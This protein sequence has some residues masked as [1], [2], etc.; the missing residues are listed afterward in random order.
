MCLAEPYSPGLGAELSDQERAVRLGRSR[1]FAALSS[2]ARVVDLRDPAIQRHAERVA[3]LACRLAAARGWQADRLEELREAA[4][5][6]DVGKLA[7]PDAVLYKPGRVDADEYEEVKRH[8]EI[9]AEIASEALSAEQVAWIR[10]H[11]ERPDGGGYPA[12]LAADVI[13]DGAQLIALADAWDVMTNAR[14]YKSPISAAAALEECRGERGHQFTAYAVDAL[15]RV[16]EIAA[17]QL[18]G[19]GDRPAGG[20]PLA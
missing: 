16:W 9:G 14:H 13:P 5:L 1:T 4:L 7:I 19:E 12:G 15:E 8:A 20:D 11:H 10:H 3:A 17:N 6:H 2:L 18:R